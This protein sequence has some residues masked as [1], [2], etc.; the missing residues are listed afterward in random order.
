VSLSTIRDFET[1][2]RSPIS[3]NIEAMRRAIEAAGVRLVF[4]SKGAAGILRR[5]AG[6][7][8]SDVPDQDQVGTPAT[9]I[10]TAGSRHGKP[11]EPTFATSCALREERMV[12]KSQINPK[13]PLRMAKIEDSSE[14]HDDSRPDTWAK[15]KALPSS[16]MNT[17]WTLAG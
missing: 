6:Q 15:V 17:I 2:R 10:P 14:P 9:P 3:N 4:D 12:R 11:N 1:G 5:D 16:L 8:L 13:P 7:D